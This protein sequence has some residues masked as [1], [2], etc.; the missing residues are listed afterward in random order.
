MTPT[1][2][3]SSSIVGARVDYAQLALA[4][5]FLLVLLVAG[6]V[7]VSMLRRW[8]RRNS[9]DRTVI[10]FTL[11]DLRRM[12]REGQ[13]SDEEFSR[14]RE[15]MLAKFGGGAPPRATGRPGGENLPPGDGTSLS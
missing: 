11:E 14:A 1:A 6:Y 4:A 2:C 5:G 9:A 8:M 12:H 13:L 15:R 7:G 10:S 3:A